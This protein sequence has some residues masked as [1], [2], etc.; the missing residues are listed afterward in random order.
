MLAAGFALL[1]ATGAVAETPVDLVE[2]YIAAYNDHDVD[3]M[4]E[5]ATPDIRWLRIDGARVQVEAD[6]AAALAEALRG[7][8]EAVP[9]SR[10]RI[11]SIQGAGQHVSLHECARWQQDERWREQCALSVYEIADGRIARVWYFPAEAAGGTP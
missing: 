8:F 4:L 5:L 2:S 1:A 7:Y 11:D 9:S 3:A 10:S 6:G